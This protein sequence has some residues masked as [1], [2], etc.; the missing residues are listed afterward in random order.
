MWHLFP[1]NAPAARV[2]VFIMTLCQESMTQH[3]GSCIVQKSC[4]H[5]LQKSGINKTEYDFPLC[6][7][8]YDSHFNGFQFSVLLF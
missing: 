7:S 1:S 2:K 4:W 8:M 5:K 6:S 3:L